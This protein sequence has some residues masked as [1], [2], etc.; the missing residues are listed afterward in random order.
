[1]KL[2]MNKNPYEIRT[3]LLELARRIL[4]SRTQ[5]DEDGNLLTVNYTTDDVINEAKKLNDFVSGKNI[6]DH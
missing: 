3:E 2:N 1:M 6:G 4:E 5:K